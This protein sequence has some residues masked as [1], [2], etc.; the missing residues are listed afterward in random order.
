MSRAARRQR[1]PRGQGARLRDELID[2]ASR[3]L[4]E[5]GDAERLSLRAVASAAG[6][7]APSIYRHFPDKRHL[8]RAVVEER[9]RRFDR[10]LEQAET[11]ATSPF[12]VLKRRCRAYLRFAREQPGHYRV[13][14]SATALGPGGVGT[15]GNGPHPGAAS[16]FALVDAVQR[17][18]DA[19]ARSDRDAFFLAVQLWTSLHGMVDLRISKPEMPW[20]SAEAQLEAALSD[21]GLTRPAT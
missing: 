9:F 8:L 6:V 2:A 3:L 13:L 16:F 19:G 10:L 17:C 1:H 14:F 7:T 18:L 21:L 12:D 15:S 20:P 5:A 4:A 11:G